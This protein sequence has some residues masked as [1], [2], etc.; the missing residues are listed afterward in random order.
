MNIEEPEKNAI[1]AIHYDNF[2]Q[3]LAHWRQSEQCAGF[4][5]IGAVECAKLGNAEKCFGRLESDLKLKA[6]RSGDQAF[7]FYAAK[8]RSWLAD[9]F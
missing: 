7:L 2:D 9:N 4:C 6:I 3:A 1:S 5:D 8:L